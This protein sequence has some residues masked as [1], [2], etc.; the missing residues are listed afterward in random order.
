MTLNDG[1]PPDDVRA[2]YIWSALYEVCLHVNLYGRRFAVTRSITPLCIR[3][4]KMPDSNTLWAAND[5]CASN[6]GPA[7]VTP[8]IVL[9]IES[10]VLSWDGRL[11]MF[12][13]IGHHRKHHATILYAGFEDVAECE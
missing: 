11:E 2:S 5:D 6:A 13:D 4:I 12:D 10:S 7:V 8:S 1:I 3:K 9:S